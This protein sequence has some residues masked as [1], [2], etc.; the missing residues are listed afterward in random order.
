MGLYLLINYARK[1]NL[2]IED[3]KAF[4]LSDNWCIVQEINAQKGYIDN[5][6]LP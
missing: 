4:K 6:I 1:H 3:V 2:K 5:K